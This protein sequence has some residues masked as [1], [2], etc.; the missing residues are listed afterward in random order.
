M[1]EEKKDDGREK[2]IKLATVREANMAT[3]GEEADATEYQLLASL[4]EVTS[5]DD[6]IHLKL[7]RCLS[8]STEC[9]TLNFEQFV[10]VPPSK[11]SRLSLCIRRWHFLGR[12]HRARL[13]LVPFYPPHL[14]CF[15]CRNLVC[16]CRT[17]M[18]V[19]FFHSL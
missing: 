9:E 11:K 3:L 13:V 4:H 12:V 2:L 1:G 6:L 7:C 5:N 14:R 8:R 15:T 19:Y 17:V 18:F 10:F 16:A